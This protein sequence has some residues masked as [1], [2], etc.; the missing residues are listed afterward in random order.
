MNHSV[1]LK[2]FNYYMTIN[3]FTY[4]RQIFLYW[5]LFLR[6][7][8]FDKRKGKGDKEGTNQKDIDFKY[9]NHCMYRNSPHL[10]LHQFKCRHRTNHRSNWYC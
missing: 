1:T 5:Q 3:I 9:R 10:V 7:G 8:E 6:G 4:F 2:L